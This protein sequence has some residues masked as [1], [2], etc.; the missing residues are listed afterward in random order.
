M[1]PM[2]VGA[3]AR[4]H[5]WTQVVVGIRSG[6]G[7]EQSNSLARDPNPGGVLQGDGELQRVAQRNEQ[8]EQSNRVSGRGIASST[9]VSGCSREALSSV[10]NT[11][12]TP[13]SIS[14]PMT[15]ARST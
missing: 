5:R 8:D 7:A 1:A 13:V 10:I 2:A 9:V 14:G 3:T 12:R 4:L 15:G 11:M 6:S